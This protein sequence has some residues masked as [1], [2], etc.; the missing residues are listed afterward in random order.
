MF[1][2]IAINVKEVATSLCTFCVLLQP[3]PRAE[4]NGA[5]LHYIVEYKQVTE[6]SSM[7]VVIQDWTVG[8]LVVDNQPIFTAYE[9]SVRAVNQMGSAAD[10]LLHVRIGHS[11]EDGLQFEK[12]SK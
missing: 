3:M 11:G 5:D 8:E 6:N 2:K 10:S 4:H 1:K 7:S 9:I 12:L